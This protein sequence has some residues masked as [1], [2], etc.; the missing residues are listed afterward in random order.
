MLRV[1]NVLNELS[2][3]KKALEIEQVENRMW[4]CRL[5]GSSV[6]RTAHGNS[7][8]LSIRETDNEIWVNPSPNTDDLDLLSAQRMMG[9]G[10]GYESRRR[11]GRTGSLL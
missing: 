1:S 10:N 4:R 6:I 8:V 11:L 5:T 7:N 9:M 3:L 2:R